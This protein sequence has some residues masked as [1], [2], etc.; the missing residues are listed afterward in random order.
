[1]SIRR[2]LAVLFVFGGLAATQQAP[3]GGIDRSDLDPTCKPCEDFWRYANGGW[4]DKNPIPARFPSWGAFPML[5]QQNRERLRIILDAAAQNTSATPGSNEQKIGDLSASCLA[6]D[7]IDAAGF[8]P[9]QPDLDRVAAIQTAADLKAAL[10]ALQR[11][12]RVG[13]LVLFATQDYKN[14]KETI[15]A[16][17]ASGL[18]LPDRDYYFTDDERNKNIRD[19]FVKHVAKT[20]GLAGDA[21]ETA[22]AEARTVM[23]FETAL[24]KATMTRVQRRDPYATYHR[25]DLAGVAELAPG[26]DWKMLLGEFNLPDSTPVNVS[27]P[28]FVKTVGHQVDTVPLADWKTW[29][30]WRLFNDAASDLSKPFRDEDFYFSK[31]VLTGV[32]EQEPRWETCAK[33]VDGDLG[34]ALGQIFVEKYFPPESKRRMQ[35]LVH[36]LRATLGDSLEK[37][38]WLDPETRKNAAA[39]LEAFYS[40]IG[41]PDRWRDYSTVSISRK[42]YFENARVAGLGNYLYRLSKIGKPLD[43]N[44]WGMTPPTVNAYYNPGRNEIVFPAGILQF[45]FFSAGADDAVNYGAIGAV[46]GHEMGH[47]FDDQGSKFDAAGNLTPWW[48]PDDR[49]KFDARATCVSDQFDSIDVGGGLHH[50]GRLVLGEAM[51]DLGG[52]T[53]AYRAYHRSLE[54]KEP[55]VIDGFTGDQRFFLSFARIWATQFRPEAA[56]LQLDTNPHPLPKYRCDAT[57]ANMPEFQKAFGCKLGD[58]MVRPAEQRCKLW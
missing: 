17:F 32:K 52:L 30:R 34:D 11:V 7:S 1:M 42:S 45:P 55:P 21:P 33:E 58:A 47:G 13:P 54:G 15:A 9:L 18:S 12:G 37:A 26:Y 40:K 41:Y 19:E 22:A 25:L 35:E 27:E 36:N 29:L 46:I 50:K 23:S 49:K 6:T 31:T 38:D 3:K 56:R 39:K 48:T 5:A 57:L 20:L 51:G 43:R 16:V 2:G 14:S 10:N 28:E 4:I 44:D 8:R 24:A 53:L